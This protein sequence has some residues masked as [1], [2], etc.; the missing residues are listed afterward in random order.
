MRLVDA[1]AFK[2]EGRELYRHVG[3]DLREVH[4]SQMD[5]E[6]NIDNM[7]T[8]EAIPVEWVED[9]KSKCFPHSI[10]WL[11]LKELLVAWKENE[12]EAD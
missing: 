5:V 10:T 9:Q 3:W 8:I 12:H 11:C 1:D 7:P 4:Y 2:A 6:C